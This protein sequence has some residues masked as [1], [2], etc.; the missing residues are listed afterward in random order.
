MHIIDPLFIGTI[1]NF[2]EITIVPS[3]LYIWTTKQIEGNAVFSHCYFGEQ[4]PKI[5]H[6]F[7]LLLS[8]EADTF[9]SHIYYCFLRI[10]S[11]ALHL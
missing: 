4:A 8:S 11:S 6:G 1:Y 10:W 5:S 7:V 9:R 2:G 3:S